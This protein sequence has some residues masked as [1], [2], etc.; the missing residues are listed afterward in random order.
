MKKGLLLILQCFIGIYLT[1]QSQNCVLDNPIDLPFNQETSYTIAVGNYVNDNLEDGS[2]SVCGVNI[3]MRHTWIKDVEVDLIS[4]AGDSVTLIGPDLDFNENTII[5]TL[6]ISFVP[7]ASDADPQFPLGDQYDNDQIGATNYKGSFYPFNGCL[8]DFNT[9][10]IIGDWVLVVRDFSPNAVAGNQ[11]LDFSIVF[12]NEAGNPCCFAD[13]GILAATVAPPT[14]TIF[15]EGDPLLDSRQIGSF[16]TNF[17]YPSLRKDPDPDRTG[18]QYDY[19]YALVNSNDSI[20]AIQDTVDMVNFSPDSYQIC[21]ISYAKSDSLALLNQ[22]NGNT[23]TSLRNDVNGATPSICAD[24]TTQ[25][26]N[27]IINPNSSPTDITPIICPGDTF[28]LGGQQFFTAG[29]YEVVLTNADGCDSLINID[30]SIAPIPEIAVDS[31]ICAGSFVTIGNNNYDVPGLYQDTLTSA[32]GCDSIVSLN[33][34]VN[35][36]EIVAL[37]STVCQGES[38]QIGNSF[39]SNPGNFQVIIPSSQ[40]CDSI[41]NLSLT[42]LDPQVV[43]NTPTIVLDCNNPTIQLNGGS[44]TGQGVLSFQWFDDANNL[45]TNGAILTVTQPGTYTLD[46]SDTVNG[47]ICNSEESVTITSDFSAPTSDAGTTDTV[48]CSN[49]TITIGGGGTS[50]GPSIGYEWQTIDG[51]IVGPSVNNTAQ[52][53]RGGSYDLIVTNMINGCRDTSTV[54]I[55]ENITP[56][57]ID[58]ALPDTLNCLQT[59]ITLSALHVSHGNAETYTWTGPG[60]VGNPNES[61]ISVDQPGIYAVV[62]TDPSNGCTE[63]QE[64]E[65]VENLTATVITSINAEVISCSVEEVSIVLE[66]DLPESQLTFNWDGPAI[67]SGLN[68]ASP[69]V[70]EPGLYTVLIENNQTG[71]QTNGSIEVVANTEKPVSDAGP[72]Q[73]IDCN[74]AMVSLGGPNTSTGND[75]TF[76]WVTNNGNILSDPTLSTIDVDSSGVYQLITSRISNGCSDTSVVTV[77]PDLAPPLVNAGGN[78]FFPCN[79]EEFVIDGRNSDDG[80]DFVYQWTGDCIVNNSDQPQVTVNCPGTYTLEVT[81]LQNGCSAQDSMQLTVDPSIPIADLA[82]SLSL[83]CNTGSVALDGSGSQGGTPSWFLDGQPTGLTGLIPSVMEEGQYTLILSDVL[84][85]CTDTATT[86]VSNPCVPILSLQAQPDSI[87]CTNQTVTINAGILPV[88][89]TYQFIWNGPNANCIISGQNTASITVTCSGIYQLIATNTILNLSDTLQVDITANQIDPMV[90]VSPP[91]TITCLNPIATLEASVTQGGIGTL[92][93]WSN[94]NGDIIGSVPVIQTSSPG[95]Y[96]LEVTNPENGCQTT[97]IV[98]VPSDLFVPEV[99]VNN[100]ELPCFQDSLRLNTVLTPNTGNYTFLWSG[101]QISGPNTDFSVLVT[102]IGSY[103]LVVTNQENGCDISVPVEVTQ[104]VCPPCLEVAPPDTITCNEPTTVLSASFCEDCNGCIL[105]W[106]TTDGQI[107]SGENSLTPTV[108]QGGLYT[109][110]ATNTVGLTSRVEVLVE[111]R[112]DEPLVNAGSDQQLTCAVTEATIGDVGLM[113]S[114]S[115]SFQ[116]LRNGVI[117]PSEQSAQITVEEGGT[118]Q[119]EVTNV[120]NGCSTIDEVEITLDTISPIAVVNDADPLNCFNNGVLVLDGSGSITNNRSVFEWSS[121]SGAAIIGVNAPTSTVQNAD[122]YTLTLRDT[123]NACQSQATVIVEEDNTPPVIIPIADQTLNCGD[124]EVVLVG[125]TPDATNFEA[126]WCRVGENGLDV[127]CDTTLTLTTDQTGNYRFQS[128]DLRNGCSAEVEVM[129]LEDSQLPIIDAGL[130]DTLTCSEASLALD[131]SI[132]AN[133]SLEIRW[134]GNNNQSITNSTIANPMINEPGVYTLLVTDPANGCVAMDSLLIILDTLPPRIDA[135]NDTIISCLSNQLTLEGVVL[136][137]GIETEANWTTINGRILSVNADKSPIID[138]PGTYYLEVVN[139]QNGCQAIDSLIVTEDFTPPIPEVNALRG[140]FLTCLLDTLILAA[141]SGG[142]ADPLR[143]S[144]D[145][146]TN[147]GSIIGANNDPS[148]QI[149][150][151]GTYELTMT[152]RRNG[153]LAATS[154]TI[155]GDF[156]PPAINVVSSPASISCILP[157]VN[158]EASANGRG[159]LSYS[160]V[161][162]NGQMLSFTS[163]SIAAQAPGTYQVIVTD[164][165]NGCADS[166]TATVEVDT[167]APQFMILPPPSLDCSIREVTLTSNLPGNDQQY[168][169]FW[170]TTEGLILDEPSSPTITAEGI[171]QYQLQVTDAANGCVA[172][173]FVDVTELASP[174]SGLDL[175]IDRPDCGAPNSG[176][177]RINNITGGTAPFQ[178]QFNGGES[179]NAPVFSNLSAGNYEVVISGADGC[180]FDTTVLITSP[181]MLAVSLGADTTINLGD[182]VLLSPIIT[183]PG[184]LVNINWDGDNGVIENVDSLNRLVAPLRNTLYRL[185][186]ENTDDCTA[187]DAI[188]IKVDQS[189]RVFFPTAFSPNGDGSNDLFGIF[190]NESVVSIDLLNIYDRWGT[191]VFSASTVFPNDETTGWDGTYKGTLL[192]PAVFT[193]YAEITFIDGKTEAFEGDVTLLR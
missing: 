66:T 185:T 60:I 4:P 82:D 67:V 37:D 173:Q 81:N 145:W 182:T 25:C 167:I 112:I 39:F 27:I 151:I 158:L 63:R 109:L 58:L 162:P 22:S 64:I 132:P 83:N 85:G 44:S 122:S 76:Q 118:Y 157:E 176:E 13:A 23:L 174:I 124:R 45:L 7:C 6:N 146:S 21:G 61:D 136:D 133:P 144:F 40:N 52:V 72:N 169:F 128:L 92:F 114:D 97:T 79:S 134:S 113:A 140:T 164:E 139:M 170:S 10:S 48:T 14:D 154:I 115:L 55:A 163:P 172:T 137:A 106:T 68:E 188:L 86:I 160:W 121:A 3:L 184:E 179:T 73:T 125:N 88:G 9:G 96:S 75:H 161:D 102:D 69:N 94:D 181:S 138:Q 117:I 186:V 153:C 129:V 65:V 152:D 29:Q 15:C 80:I 47:I 19:T 192:N 119:L 95:I 189:R 49:P 147:N 62:V 56:P 91:S 34:T 8:E 24:I 193:Y 187:G 70:S 103:N 35:P 50:T 159:T 16:S 101:D 77:I 2:Q 126:V 111:E 165:I 1:A 87:T 175:F 53:D 32:L 31:S 110:T 178:Y 51:N 149:D 131:P 171:G 107:E 42:V 20:V 93:S 105:N 168:S 143:W 116:W 89:P 36:I 43:I 46:V 57:I 135:G 166:A 177:M 74:S 33:L 142:N 99:T 84:S 18:L 26:I 17:V 12:C 5:T 28:N 98:E 90:N 191:L 156:Q 150:A 127:T 30:L 183:S 180:I 38:V 120:R 155:E 59:N 123:V 71:C 100:T 130:N 104:P 11:I 190:A 78:Q 141:E 41:I 148:I 108:A 54:R